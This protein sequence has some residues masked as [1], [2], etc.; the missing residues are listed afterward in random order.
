[1]S[2]ETCEAG[3]SHHG[4]P[5]FKRQRFGQWGLNRIEMLVEPAQGLKISWFRASDRKIHAAKLFV[6]SV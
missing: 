6:L 4:L 5:T 2:D 3:L 1:M